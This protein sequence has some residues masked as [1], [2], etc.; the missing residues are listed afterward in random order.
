MDPRVMCDC[1]SGFRSDLPTTNAGSSL[2]VP[3]FPDAVQCYREI[4]L[5]YR[6]PELVLFSKKRFLSQLPGTLLPPEAERVY[7]SL[8]AA[9]LC[10]RVRRQLSVESCRPP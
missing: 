10:E 5:A 7:E 8:G 9:W 1:S 4:H 2:N 6:T 3:Y